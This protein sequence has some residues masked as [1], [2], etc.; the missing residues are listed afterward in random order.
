MKLCYNGFMVKKSDKLELS[1]KTVDNAEPLTVAGRETSGLRQEKHQKKVMPTLLRLG[2]SVLF[3]GA[4]SAL[5]NWFVFVRQNAYDLDAVNAFITEKPYLFAYSNLVIF[6]IMLIFATLTWTTFLS[7]GIVFSIISIVSFI[8]MKK[9]EIRGI[10]LLPEDFMLAGAAGEMTEFVDI[11][12]I[13]RLVAGVILV[14]VG[15]ALLE[16]CARRT[17][18]RETKELPWWERHSLVPR[19]C[20]T[21]VAVVTLLF[22]VEPVIRQEKDSWIEGV[23][24]TVWGPTFTY[25]NNGF[26]IGFLSN[27][28]KLDQSKPESYNEEEMQRIA[29]KYRAIKAADQGRLPLDKVLDNLVIILDETFYDP[30]LYDLYA[31]TG[32]DIL[33]E[34]HAI[35][36]EYPSGYMYSPEYGGGTANIEFEVF[37]GLTNYWAQNYPYVNSLAKQEHIS[38]VASWAKNFNFNTTA[39]HSYDGSFYKRN[40]IYPSMGFN[41]FIDE[42]K[43]KYTETEN[44]SEYINDRSLFKEV[45][46][47]LKNSDDHHMIGAI[48]MQ[49]HSPYTSAVYPELDFRL[50]SSAK[51][52]WDLENSFQSLYNSDQY[53]GEFLEEL[54]DLDEKTVVLL[55]GDHTAGILTEYAN[56][57]D[58]AMRGLAHLTPYFIYTNFEIPEKGEVGA[59]NAG[60]VAAITANSQVKRVEVEKNVAAARKKNLELGFDIK[61][62]GVDLSITTPNCLLNNVYNLLNVEKP[63]MFYLLD[64]VCEETPILSAGYFAGDDPEETEALYDYKLVTYD[65]L[66]GKQYWDGN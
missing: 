27:L 56:S 35:F 44:I 48:T 5:F 43:M 10:P 57:E 14:L 53:I 37:T 63:S 20:L 39:I 18:G 16:W 61:T 15:S 11:W 29:D 24:W 7:T 31:H 23:E 62:K 22:V 8:N 6:L 26:V 58:A 13:V 4:M 36:E 59:G 33:P 52:S 64:I 30:E 32:G 42:D 38:G 1:T 40:V 45:L 54:G 55:F 34:T 2:L 19:I 66:S 49:N 46:D 17:I 51:Q 47:V 50:Y 21:L 28:G 60:T 41:E 9:L 12:Q 25:E 3:I 65:I